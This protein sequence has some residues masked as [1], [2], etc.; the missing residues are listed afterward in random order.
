[1]T[2]T[3]RTRN[4]HITQVRTG[5]EVITGRSVRTVAHVEARDDLPGFAADIRFTDDTVMEYR[6]GSML[7]VAR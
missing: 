3:S 4:L 6:D 7:V 1:M 5:H 2:T